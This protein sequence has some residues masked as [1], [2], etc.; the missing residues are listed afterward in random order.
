MTRGKLG[1]EVKL[2]LVLSL[3]EAGAEIAPPEATPDDRRGE[4]EHGRRRSG[5]THL[6]TGG[7]SLFVASTPA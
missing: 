3:G 5:G 2:I 4:S 1:N 6:Q 7:G